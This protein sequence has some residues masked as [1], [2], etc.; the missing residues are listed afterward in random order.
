[1]FISDEKFLFL[2]LSLVERKDLVYDA[3]HGG[4]R[5]AGHVGGADIGAR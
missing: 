4:G 3:Q 2:A 5:V 1:M